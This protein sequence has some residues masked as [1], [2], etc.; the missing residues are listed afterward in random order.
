MSVRTV[1]WL[2][3][4][5]LFSQQHSVSARLGR[6]AYNQGVVR[7]TCAQQC[8]CDRVKGCVGVFQHCLVCCV[9]N[10]IRHAVGGMLRSLVRKNKS[11]DN[12]AVCVAETGRGA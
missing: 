9:Y 12:V 7:V 8:C 10:M 5:V 3:R 1:C 11:R 2:A 6:N 4:A